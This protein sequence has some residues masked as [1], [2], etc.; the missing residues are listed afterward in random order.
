[1][2]PAIKSVEGK[3]LTILS[4]RGD[5]Q[6]VTVRIIRRDGSEYAYIKQSST[7][8][9]MFKQKPARFKLL[10]FKDETSPAIGA[11]GALL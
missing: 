5:P 2:L 6:E 4:S 1:M 8:E 9:R 3:Q 7:F 11:K 10:P